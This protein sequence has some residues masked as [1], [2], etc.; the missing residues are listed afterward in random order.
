MHQDITDYHRLPKSLSNIEALVRTT[1]CT[2]LLACLFALS[3][4][5]Y[6]GVIF[7]LQLK[8]QSGTSSLLPV[9]RR[10]LSK[11]KA[12]FGPPAQ[13]SSAKVAIV[14]PVIPERSAIAGDAEQQKLRPGDF[15][16][17]YCCFPN[18]LRGVVLV[19]CAPPLS[20]FD[21]RLQV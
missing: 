10:V 7:P 19:S 13:A 3:F 11:W 6:G 2:R 18:I 17:R 1:A 21:A 15:G 16:Y 14:P 20:A 8:E 4:Y 5:L 9:V 12:L